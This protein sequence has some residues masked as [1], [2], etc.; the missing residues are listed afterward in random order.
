MITF[1]KREFSQDLVRELSQ[2]FPNHTFCSDEY[3]MA[4]I[5]ITTTD[6]IVYS[7]ERMIGIRYDELIED[8]EIMIE[9]EN[10]EDAESNI[11]DIAAEDI[12]FYID[13]ITKEND[14]EYIPLFINEDFLPEDFNL[15]D[16]N[17]LVS[18]IDP[19]DQE[20]KDDHLDN[21]VD[22]KEG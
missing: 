6:R 4:I 22:H 1:Y 17:S 11:Q 9:Y 21:S 3:D 13:G 2:R 16:E 20:E 18:Y 12:C 8:R 19:D 5:G 10:D 14:D 7:Y 15:L